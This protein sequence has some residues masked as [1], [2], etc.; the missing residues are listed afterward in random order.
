[1]GYDAQIMDW[2]SKKYKW[3]VVITVNQECF[4]AS[5]WENVLHQYCDLFKEA[6][7]MHILPNNV[8]YGEN[9]WPSY[10][11]THKEKLNSHTWEA[12]NHS[13]TAGMTQ[14]VAYFSLGTLKGQAAVHRSL[15]MYSLAM[16]TSCHS[17]VGGQ[18]ISTGPQS[19]GL[20]PRNLSALSANCSRVVVFFF[21]LLT[22]FVRLRF[23]CAHRLLCA[24][25]AVTPAH[26]LFG[27]AADQRPESSKMPSGSALFIGRGIRPS[28]VPWSFS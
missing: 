25:L 4:R 2:S 23:Y 3:Q 11:Y 22:V 8:F 5:R 21:N 14:H 16:I 10:I 27:T 9:K 19:R 13:V 26:L 12:I 7:S 28:Q 1:M 18:F 15:F 24:T 20:R 17:H 6:G